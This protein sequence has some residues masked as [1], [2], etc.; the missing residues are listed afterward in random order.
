MNTIIG[1]NQQIA[2]QKE[3]E[4]YYKKTAGDVLSVGD[5][6]LFYNPAVK[7]GDS[8]KFAPCY[9]GPFIIQ[10]KRGEEF[11]RNWWGIGEWYS[12]SVRESGSM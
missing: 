12:Q 8:K 5:H 9:Q 6:V 11:M 1:D 7:I 3:Q 2:S 4:R 10:H